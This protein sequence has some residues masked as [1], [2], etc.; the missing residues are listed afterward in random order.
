MPPGV[1]RAGCAREPPKRAIAKRMATKARP[2]I[3]T[4][5]MMLPIPSPMPKWLIS[6]AMPRPAARPAS[7]PI[8][9][10]LGAGAAGAAAAAGV[11]GAACAGLAG[12]ALGAAEG[13]LRC[14]PEEPP[15]PMRLASAAPGARLAD[16]TAN[17]RARMSVFMEA[18]RS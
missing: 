3:S 2:A 17:D 5:M 12:A 14:M 11:V 15:P 7:G 8:H 10:R 13:V 16:S 1:A 6:A 9:E 4:I 18:V